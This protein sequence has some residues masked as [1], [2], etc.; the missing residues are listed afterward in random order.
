MWQRP[1]GLGRVAPRYGLVERLQVSPLGMWHVAS[2][3]VCVQGCMRLVVKSRICRICVQRE[4]SGG[5]VISGLDMPFTLHPRGGRANATRRPHKGHAGGKRWRTQ[6]ARSSDP[7]DTLQGHN[8]RRLACS[9][10]VLGQRK[11]AAFLVCR[12][13]GL[14]ESQSRGIVHSDLD[15]FTRADG[16]TILCEVNIAAFELVQMWK[17]QVCRSSAFEAL[18]AERSHVNMIKTTVSELPY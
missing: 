6:W 16:E 18:L 14:C 15:P 7:R 10:R 5:G 2:Y 1:F 9:H 17:D 8:P 4:C 12:S 11:E 3:S 13:T